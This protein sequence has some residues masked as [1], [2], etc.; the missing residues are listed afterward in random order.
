MFRQLINFFQTPRK[1]KNQL[2]ELTATNET[3]RT[4]I[5]HAL[6]ACSILASQT[7]STDF[8]KYKTYDTA[9]EAIRLKYEGKSDYG[10]ALV[11]QIV[12]LRGSFAIGNGIKVTFDGK[13]DAEAR[14]IIDEF[15]EDNGLDKEN[16][17]E[18]AK[19]AEIEGQIAVQLIKEK[20]PKTKKTR[21][22]LI[23][24]PWTK[25]KY[26]VTQGK[27][28]GEYTKLEYQDPDKNNM[29]VKL[30]QGEFVYKKF[31]GRISDAETTT[32]ITNNA[33]PCIGF[34]LPYIDSADMA[35]DDWRAINNLF[36]SPTPYFKTETREDAN[37]ISA[38]IAAINW[39]P[40]KAFA[41]NAEFTF[42]SPDASHI[43][44]LKEEIVVNIQMIS[45]ITGIPVHFLGMPDLMSNR[46]TAESL[47][48]L[49]YATSNKPRR[50]WEGFYQELYEKLL[51]IYV[52]ELG[53]SV[54]PESVT[55]SIPF[56]TKE[57]FDQLVNVWLPVWR[58][59]GLSL[60]TFLSKVPD[61]DPEEEKKKI[62][63]IEDEKMQKLIDTMNQQPEE[64]EEGNPENNKRFNNPNAKKNQNPV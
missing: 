15:N 49:V 64:G 62:D 36:A 58:E 32:G 59:G 54:E 7:S 39:K 3:L 34:A 23:H 57:Q 11:K 35:L 56:F 30:G 50:I 28:Y 43:L 18:L 53:K 20:D 13:E 19:E 9:I 46:S 45:A 33:I 25:Y 12:E 17:G 60:E 40:G 4:Q 10:N 42:I 61:I 41:G 6:D 29:I 55:V 52:A 24:L 31:S 16:L 26:K 22:F 44:I 1:W 48:E 63:K 38:T 5:N 8:N 51:T 27:K 47:F 14:Q 2:E 21:V 37:N